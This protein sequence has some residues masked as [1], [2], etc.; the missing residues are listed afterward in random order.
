MASLVNSTKY[1]KNYLL[2]LFQTHLIPKPD[3]ETTKKKIT[4]QCLWTLLQKPST[5]Y[6]WCISCVYTYTKEGNTAVCNNTDGPWGHNA[7]WNKRQVP[8]LSTYEKWKWSCSVVS[9]WDSMD[10]S[11]PGSSVQGIFQA[12]ILE[13]V[14]ISF[15]R[16][17]SQLRDWTWVSCIAGR[18]ST[19]WATREPPSYLY[20]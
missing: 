19:V 4:G 10:G 3:K 5:K 9:L 16:G 18:L 6:M 15:S 17:S 12:R 2:K 1:L 20:V 14:A 7:K 11:P 8:V 13:W